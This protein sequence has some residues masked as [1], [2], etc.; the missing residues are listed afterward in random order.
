MA[1]A[2]GT[3]ATAIVALFDFQSL[4]NNP[5]CQP[6]LRGLMINHG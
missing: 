3:F 1:A 2:S 5:A 4:R 6:L